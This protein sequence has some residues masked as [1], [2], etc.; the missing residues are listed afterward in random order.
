MD[1]TARRLHRDQARHVGQ[2]AHLV[3]RQFRDL[4][5]LAQ[6]DRRRPGNPRHGRRGGG[7][8]RKDVAPSDVLQALFGI[9]S[10]PATP[11]W[12]PRSR[13]IVSLIMD[14]L[15]WGRRRAGERPG[16]RARTPAGVL[17]QFRNAPARPT[18]SVGTTRLRRHSGAWGPLSLRLAL[19]LIRTAAT[20]LAI[21]GAL[22]RRLRLARLLISGFPVG[23]FAMSRDL[24][25]AGLPC[26]GL[27]RKGLSRNGFSCGGLPDGGLSYSGLPRGAFPRGSFPRPGSFA[28][29]PS[30][31][32]P[33]GSGSITTSE[34][35]DLRSAL[36]KRS[37]PA[38]LTSNA[39][40]SSNM[41]M[42]PMSLRVTFPRRHISG[43]SQRGSAL[44]RRPILR[45]NHALPPAPDGPLNS[46]WAARSRTARGSP[47]SATSSGAGRPAR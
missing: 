44:L 2:P 24:A 23:R 47:G 4:R 28:R 45:R 32:G 6:P 31:G 39:V 7:T 36:L 17:D 9:Y 10:A 40:S 33:P 41:R 8:I 1:A 46:R 3:R 25:C 43:N 37:S 42:T 11:D 27:S 18:P 14:G 26:A 30:A 12:E 19:E 16:S 38:P 21:A 20:G 15:R 13:R 22:A 29:R 34:P 35:S 5:R